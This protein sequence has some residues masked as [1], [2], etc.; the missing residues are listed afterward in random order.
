MR[1][2]FNKG[3]RYLLAHR[4]GFRCSRPDCRAATAG[5]GFRANKI[6]S[7]G[8]AAHITAASPGG[9][10]YDS[11]INPELRG[12][13]ENGIWLCDSHAREIDKDVIRFSTPTLLAW[14]Q[15]A[16]EQA[17][18]LL[19]RPI[20][21]LGLN[22]SIE[23]T[24]IRDA[25]DSI[26]IV[27]ATNLPAGT[28][29]M[30]D[31]RLS[32]VSQYHSQ[33]KCEVSDGLFALGPFTSRGDVLP[34]SFYIVKVFSY[35][36]AA[37]AQPQHVLNLTGKNGA[38]LSGRLAIPIDR[39]LDESNYSVEAVFECA[40]PLS[41]T[42][43]PLSKH[44]IVNSIAKLQKSIIEVN[45]K[46]PLLS[47]DCIGDVVD[48]FLQAPGIKLNTGWS[49]HEFS[50]GVV[51]VVFSFYDADKPNTAIWHILPRTNQVRY[52]NRFAKFMSWL[53]KD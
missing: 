37:W 38:Q 24:L 17:R 46:S 11:T 19:G 18:A 16:E 50:P 2:E 33:D 28:K 12:S 39:D 45:G 10:R 41:K 34:Q 6:G 31:F 48:H 53:P 3:V 44:E 35:F 22:V 1:D 47:S 26:L 20:S 23:V 36:N 42:E 40:A 13:I 15:H 51:E 49:A 4:A 5:P 21:S 7:I 27:G 14:K 8:I 43:L 9:P 25:N 30:A 29:L 52:R 32:I